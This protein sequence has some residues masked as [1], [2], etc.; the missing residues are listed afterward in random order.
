MAVNG[1]NNTQMINANPVVPSISPKRKT[2]ARKA[3]IS[4]TRPTPVQ[5]KTATEILFGESPN[6]HRQPEPPFIWIDHPQQNER[7]LASVYAV[8]LGVGGAQAVEISLDK[9]SWIPCRLTSG[10]WWYD[11]SNIKPGK[12]T[13]VARM[14]TSEGLWYKTPPRTCDYRA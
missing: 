13:L 6:P 14:R 2:A 4:A 5:K 9:G 11:W 1:P 7:L 10:Y 12:H 8:R 3:P